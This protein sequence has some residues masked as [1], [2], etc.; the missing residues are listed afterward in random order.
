MG[1]TFDPDGE[2]QGSAGGKGDP[3]LPRLW[4]KQFRQVDVYF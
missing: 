2:L 4:P 1:F 3:D